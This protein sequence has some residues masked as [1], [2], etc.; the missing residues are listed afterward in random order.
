MTC[1]YAVFQRQVGGK[2]CIAYAPLTANMQVHL[3][4]YSSIV[5]PV[6]LALIREVKIGIAVVCLYYYAVL[7]TVFHQFGYIYL[8]R[9]V[10][11]AQM[12]TCLLTVH[13]HY[14]VM[15]NC[16]ELQS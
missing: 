6:E 3:T 7:L 1:T 15:I 14:S 13:I 8:K 16:F 5:S 2:V 12:A 11:L 4:I 10:A 9:S